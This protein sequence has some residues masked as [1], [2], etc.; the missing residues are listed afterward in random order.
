MVMLTTKRT[1]GSCKKKRN[2]N[3][4]WWHDWIVKC[5]RKI[6]K[7]EK[8]GLSKNYIK[9]LEVKLERLERHEK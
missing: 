6:Q 1:G 7:A 9:D 3:P 5:V 2:P 4:N 8:K